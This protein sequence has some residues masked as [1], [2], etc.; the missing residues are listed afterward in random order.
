[1][2]GLIKAVSIFGIILIFTI[3]PSC[4]NSSY[5]LVVKVEKEFIKL[6]ERRDSLLVKYLGK[7]RISYCKALQLM[8]NFERDTLLYKYF[9]P[10]G[11][12]YLIDWTIKMDK[13]TGRN[14]SW[15]S[16]FT[17]PT[18]RNFNLFYIDIYTWMRFC[19]C[20]YKDDTEDYVYESITRGRG[21]YLLDSSTTKWDTLISDTSFWFEHIEIDSLRRYKNIYIPDSLE[22]DSIY[23]Y[24]DDYDR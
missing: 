3:N 16:T 21:Y 19:D 22:Y 17:G 4:N 2:K 23:E 12:D 20:T 13:K 1:M 11:Y 6:E 24:K 10:N 8:A 9:S 18:Y 7:K 5:K 15:E 14:P